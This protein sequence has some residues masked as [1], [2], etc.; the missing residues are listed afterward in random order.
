MK[1]PEKL[2]DVFER[3][4]AKGLKPSVLDWEEEDFQKY[5][6]E[7]KQYAYI[8]FS[9][10]VC[11]LEGQRFFVSGKFPNNGFFTTLTARREKGSPKKTDVIAKQFFAKIERLL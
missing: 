6:T 9:Q 8:E 7:F 4:E 1:A 2:T 3:M 10:D 5:L 11:L